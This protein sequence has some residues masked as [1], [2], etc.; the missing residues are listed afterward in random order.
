LSIHEKITPKQNFFTPQ[1]IKIIII[2]GTAVVIFLSLLAPVGIL[3][4]TTAILAPVL[5]VSGSLLLVVSIVMY[6]RGVRRQWVFFIALLL[7]LGAAG[8]YSGGFIGV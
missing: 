5:L 4:L 3:F 1:Q 8:L 6:L 7:L 2:L